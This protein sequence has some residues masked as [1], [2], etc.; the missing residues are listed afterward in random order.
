MSPATDSCPKLWVAALDRRRLLTAVGGG[1]VALAGLT[2][3]RP[4][5]AA[6]GRS[7]VG[8]A[9]DPAVFDAS[10][11][12]VSG[13]IEKLLDSALAATFGTVDGVAGLRTC[14]RPTDV[15]GVKVNC[16]AGPGLSTHVELVEA[17]IGKLVRAGVRADNVIVWDRSDRD[18]KRARYAI[19]RVG[20]GPLV[21]GTNDDYESDPI[22]AGSVGGCLSRILT[23]NVTALI[24]V[25]I[26]KDHDLAGISG[27]MKNFYGAIH[28]PNRF[29]DAGCAPYIADL[30][31]HPAIKGKV[32][33]TIFDALMP[34]YH[35]GP[36]YVPAHTWKKGA[37]FASVDPVAADTIGF[38]II[39]EK[40]REVGMESLDQAGRS[41]KWLDR[42]TAMGLGLRDE[43]QITEVHR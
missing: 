9:R 20:Q 39:R 5:V 32:R 37:I 35:G 3:C 31:A 27:G 15:V 13:A 40:R 25:P 29:H 7:R 28:N 18:L 23:R 26:L 34:Q 2:T 17:L 14:F 43:A 33:L 22:E 4:T 1:A 42:A 8:V 30:N 12:F 16:L 36:A 38:R 41:P 19:K 11:R 24:S 21:Y 6:T 10:D